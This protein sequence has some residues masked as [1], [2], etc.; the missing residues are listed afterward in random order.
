MDACCGL[1]LLAAGEWGDRLAAGRGRAGRI[2]LWL[3]L[4]AGCSALANVATT[5]RARILVEQGVVQGAVPMQLYGFALSFAM[6]LLYFAHLGRSAPARRRSGAPRRHA[7][8]QREARRRMVQGDLQAV[9]ARIDPGA[10]VRHARGGAR[11]VRHRPAA[12][13]APARRTDRLP[14]GV[15][16]SLRATAPACRARPNWPAPMPNCCRW[17]RAAA[18]A[19]R[20]TCPTPPCTRASRR[21]RCCRWW[22]TRCAGAAATATWRHAA[23][24]APAA[25]R[26]CCRH[27][28]P[29]S[30]SPACRPA[31]R[32]RRR[33][34]AA[35]PSACLGDGALLSLW[36]PHA[37][38]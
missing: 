22:T 36:V 4:A 20:W 19:W 17:R 33:R 12:R 26:C 18:G 6:A 24:T 28:L 2:A 31:A 3:A 35:W 9:Q 29:T 11:R 32:D 5:G 23:S 10:A 7:G 27:A 13:R 34:R 15:L 8:G 37:A 30:P 16:P 21:A 14:A 38:A 25:S 1:P